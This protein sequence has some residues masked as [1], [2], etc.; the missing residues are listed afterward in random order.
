MPVVL[1]AQG[2][3]RK[4]SMDFYPMFATMVPEVTE[5]D[6]APL[7]EVSELKF[8]EVHK[9]KLL[10]SLNCYLADAKIFDDAPSVQEVRRRLEKINKHSQEFATLL[11]DVEPPL[12]DPMLKSLEYRAKRALLRE[13]RTAT[14]QTAI[15]LC[16]PFHRIDPDALVRILRELAMSSGVSARDLERGK[17]GRP[18]NASL[19]RFLQ[20]VG[21]VFDTAG[22]RGIVGAHWREGSNKYSGR[23]SG[24]LL[25]LICELL[26]QAKKRGGA[27]YSRNTIAQRIKEL[28]RAA[29]R[30]GYK[31][32][33]SV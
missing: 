15:R 31:R 2:K 22:G 20:E 19:E 16:F 24:R 7:E 3:N 10:E 30:K 23:Y 6:F 9:R 25:K 1:R 4:L 28:R 8:K 17:S 5:L 12:D 13:E 27:D 29:K 18:P 32:T 26:E 11:S 21:E 14:R 33:I